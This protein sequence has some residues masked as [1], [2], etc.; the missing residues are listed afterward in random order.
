MAFVFN[1]PVPH[2]QSKIYLSG[3]GIFLTASPLP[4]DST[5]SMTQ[6]WDWQG[7]KGRWTA[8]QALMKKG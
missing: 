6:H 4:F 2:N 3:S 8:M 5:C 7:G 1:V